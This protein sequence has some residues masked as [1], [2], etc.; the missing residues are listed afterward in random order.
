MVL[1][2]GVLKKVIKSAYNIGHLH[3]GKRDGKYILAG[4]WWFIE[5]NESNLSNKIKAAIMELTG[6]LP[7]RGEFYECSKEDIQME[8]PDVAVGV[9][10]KAAEFL[11]PIEWKKTKILIEKASY[12]TR[13]YQHPEKE[14]TDIE[15]KIAVNE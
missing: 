3:M 1:N 11:M 14:K 2:E 6:L 4:T 9:L 10:D 7:E 13:I 15:G 5:I 8:F 12:I